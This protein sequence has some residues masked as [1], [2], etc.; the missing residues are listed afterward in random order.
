MAIKP[1]VLGDD[2][3]VA[4]FKALDEGLQGD[5]LENATVVGALVIVNAAKKNVKANG[6][7]GTRTM[8]RSIHVG[9]HTEKTSDFS[10]GKDY[11]DVGGLVNQGTRVEVLAGTNL[12]YAPPHEFGG[13]IRPKTGKYLAIPIGSYRGSP[14]SHSDLQLRKSRSGN[15]LLVDASG[16]PQYVL[17]ESVTIPARPFMRP[18]HDDNKTEVQGAIGE[19][20][21]QQIEK[22][23]AG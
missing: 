11:S 23:A 9:G 13:V 3:L 15:L 2:E 7:I 10:G 22:V 14:R 17:K 8:S 1:E 6:L 4:K 20:I 21:K 16:T 12:V 18:A 5:V 19:A